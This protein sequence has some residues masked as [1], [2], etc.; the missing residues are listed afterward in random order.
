MA[1]EL[2]VTCTTFFWYN[3]PLMEPQLIF[4]G[5]TLLNAL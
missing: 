1:L 3:F 2:S 5:K 4:V